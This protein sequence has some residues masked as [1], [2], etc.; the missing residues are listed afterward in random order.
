MSSKR[1]A[2]AWSAA[3]RRLCLVLA[4]MVLGEG[5]LQDGDGLGDE[6]GVPLAPVLLGERH[7]RSGPHTIECSGYPQDRL[8][9]CEGQVGDAAR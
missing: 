4:E 9:T 5:G 3:D 8:S 1:G 7:D 2:S 6:L